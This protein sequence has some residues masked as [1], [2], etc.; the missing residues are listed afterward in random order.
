M[1]VDYEVSEEEA[2][3]YVEELKS[4]D[5]NIRLNALRHM[6]SIA[7]ILGSDRIANELIPFVAEILEECDNEDEFLLTLCDEL[8]QLRTFLPSPAPLLMPFEQLA[9][10]E[11][12]VIRERAVS[13]IVELC[14]KQNSKFY[15]DHFIPVIKRLVSWET[16]SSKIS[17]AYLIPVALQNLSEESD[18]AEWFS[19]FVNLSK[20]DTPMVRRAAAVNLGKCGKTSKAFVPEVFNVFFRLIQDPIDSVKQKLI[21][22]FPEVAPLTSDKSQIEKCILQILNCAEN[23]KAWRVKY[24]IPQ[25]LATVLSHCDES[26]CSVHV[27][28]FLVGMLKEPEPEIRSVALQHFPSCFHNFRMS[29]GEKISVLEQKIV[30][31]FKE[32][33]H[34]ESY[35]VRICLAE[36][37]AHMVKVVDQDI[38]NQPK[39]EACLASLGEVMS[40]LFQDSMAEVRNALIEG[41]KEDIPGL[42]EGTFMK[43]ILPQLSSLSKDKQWRTKLLAV[44]ILVAAVERYSCEK[45]PQMFEIY[46]EL[47]QEHTVAIR[48]RVFASLCDAIEKVA[49]KQPLIDFAIKQLFIMLSHSSYL[50]RVTGLKALGPLL[51]LLGSQQG[52]VLGEVIQKLE[53]EKVINVKTKSIEMIQAIKPV[54]EKNGIMKGQIKRFLNKMAAEANEEL[55]SNAK[56]LLEKI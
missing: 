35:H 14:E 46:S 22:G 45:I 40:K 28:P 2:A 53:N 36:C 13:R 30:P 29:P 3:L 10:L 44:D 16:Y 34:D 31:G 8:F 43:I 32:L 48:D 12:W 6:K 38:R 27:V 23:K 18:R 33:D 24:Y 19:V 17:A 20:D 49:S 56:E 50:Y 4:Y 55:A 41:T 1:E 26:F 37:V 9:A 7:E 54:Y 5:S 15:L 39:Y 11:E 51:P 42:S 52:R 25:L 47:L 21:E